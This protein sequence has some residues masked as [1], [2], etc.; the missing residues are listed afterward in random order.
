MTK[1]YFEVAIQE[2][3]LLELGFTEKVGRVE[4]NFVSRSE[5]NLPPLSYDNSQ[6]RTYS[7]RIDEMNTLNV[8]ILK[9]DNDLI[10]YK[11][12]TINSNLNQI[13]I[14]FY[15]IRFIH[16]IQNIYSYLTGKELKEKLK[17]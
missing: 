1:K 2:A 10:A 15:H 16:E 3:P 11:Q 9:D 12:V 6:I 17:T 13:I 4:T 7:F 14:A 5:L 8:D